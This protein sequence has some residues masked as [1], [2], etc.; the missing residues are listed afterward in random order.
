MARFAVTI[1]CARPNLERILP[2]G[3][4]ERDWAQRPDRRLR[5]R[6]TPPPGMRDDRPE[7]PCLQPPGYHE[8]P[9]VAARLS[10]T[11]GFIFLW[12]G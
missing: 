1:G 5:R 11:I 12:P 2:Q 9:R 3:A 6:R 7:A 8:F 10:A 4:E